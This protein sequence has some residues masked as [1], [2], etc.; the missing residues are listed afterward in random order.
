[1]NAKTFPARVQCPRCK[2]LFT[3]NITEAARRSGARNFGFPQLY[4]PD[5][6]AE[7][8]LERQRAFEKAQEK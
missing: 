6:L 5:C 7:L 1:M 4:H 8:C 2:K 3:L